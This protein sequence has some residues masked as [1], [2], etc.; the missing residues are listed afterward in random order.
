MKLFSTEQG[1][2]IF[3]MLQN[4]GKALMLPIAIL[5]AA[6]LLLGI[7]DTLSNPTTLK[8]LEFLNIR[9]LQIIFMLMKAAGNIVFENLPILFAVGISTGLARQDKGTVGLA[10]ILSML[11]TNATIHTALKLTGKLA[12][13][14]IASV[15]QGM[16]L[17]IQTLETGVF[18][19][20]LVGLMVY[21]LHGK[22]YKVDLPPFLGFFSGSRFVPIICAGASICLGICLYVIWPGFQLTILGF[23]E[24]FRDTGYIGT[25][26]YG[27]I[28]RML[29][30]FGLHHIF[31]LPFW[32]TGLGGSELVSGQLIEGTQRI[33]FAQ[34]SD[35]STAKFYEG[36]SRFMSGRFITMM[37]GLV[38]AAF[39]LYKTAKPQNKKIVG[40]M[41][42]SAA[43]TS[44]L[45]GITEPLEFSFLFAAPMLYVL[46]AFFDGCAFM[47]A[48]IFQITIGQTFSG[49]LIDFI[50]FGIMQGNV[51]TNW[52][53]VPL[54]GVPWFFLYYF[55]FKFLIEKYDF[56][57][58]GREE[59]L[60]TE[61][62]VLSDA[63]Q[64]QLILSGLGGRENIE[65]LDNCITR[66]RVTVKDASLVNEE[67][68]K[69]S[70]AQGIIKQGVGV[71]IIYGLRVNN[72]K[73]NLE[74]ALK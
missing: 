73:N 37:F 59:D 51:K 6:G 42:F 9:W 69:T 57:T 36:I 12:E 56:K 44:F 13:E 21:W 45:T 11:I 34:L 63:E 33:F 35:P 25:L 26:I 49:G 64:T 22:F 38:G 28:L 50:L 4:F 17:G 66:L 46:H 58:P 62:K 32:T 48:H 52:I 14:H 1:S 39:A 24:L 27:F 43:L 68:L 18:G 19:G 23:G 55:S 3:A 60:L 40:G 41:L 74:E 61:Q 7:G 67:I 29:G 65:D 15:G 2:S 31:Y 72:I 16:C 54:I 8:A 70:G 30:L 53:Y 71:Q 10:A 20:M 47:L 5:P